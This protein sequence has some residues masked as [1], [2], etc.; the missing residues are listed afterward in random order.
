VGSG[1]HPDRMNPSRIPTGDRIQIAHRSSAVTDM[2][3]GGSPAVKSFPVSMIEN[4]D[5]KGQVFTQAD[6]QVSE[7]RHHRDGFYANALGGAGSPWRVHFGR[8]LSRYAAR[9]D[10]E[11]AG[12]FAPW[13]R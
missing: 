1:R 3:I 6:T 7:R 12:T 11:Q 13:I 2:V 10:G 8:V 5:F 9:P 4:S